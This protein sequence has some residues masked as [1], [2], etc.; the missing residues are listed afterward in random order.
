MAMHCWAWGSA[1]VKM[2]RGR[3][4][5]ATGRVVGGVAW[6]AGSDGA[7][8]HFRLVFWQQGCLDGLYGYHAGL[9]FGFPFWTR[10]M[11][12]SGRQGQLR[13]DCGSCGW[14]EAQFVERH[15]GENL[16]SR[17]LSGKKI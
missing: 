2:A 17:V 13:V 11:D 6:M 14:S 7:A 1:L 8:S 16:L 10:S 4:L 3:T 15:Y 9:S 5:V 12:A